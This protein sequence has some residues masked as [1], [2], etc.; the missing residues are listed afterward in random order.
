MVRAII[1]VIVGYIT[2]FVF[3]FA[4]FSAAYF[5]MGADRAFKPGVYEVSI[6]WTAIS[7]ILGLIASI[8]GGFV[9]VKIARRP[10]PGFVLAGIAL[11]LGIA[12]AFPAVAKPDPGPRAADVSNLEAM[13]KAKQPAWIAFFN[14]ILGAAGI[15]LGVRLASRR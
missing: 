8:L 13:S 3:I 7:F 9:C 15:A 5:A 14:P 11:V 6:L 12:M 2:M 4:S 10:K 1:G